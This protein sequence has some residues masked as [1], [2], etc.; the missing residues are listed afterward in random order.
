MSPTAAAAVGSR[1]PIQPVV[2]PSAPGLA[3]GQ[4]PGQPAQ[5]MATAAKPGLS[6]PVMLAAL[7][8]AG[9]GALMLLRRRKK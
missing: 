4:I 6:R 8:I 5:A 9:V 2:A 3:P 1:A 7:A